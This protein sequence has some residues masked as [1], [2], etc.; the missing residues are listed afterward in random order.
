MQSPINDGDKPEI[1]LWKR[2]GL[3]QKMYE[4]VSAQA[5][6][7][8]GCGIYSFAV[9]GG[10]EVPL[11]IVFADSKLEAAQVRS[12]VI[13]GVIRAFGLRAHRTQVLRADDGYLQYV[14]LA[15][16]LSVCEKRIGIDRLLAM[17][18]HDQRISY[19][20]CASIFL[21]KP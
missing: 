7:S 6:G 21:D 16:A 4:I 17:S 5:N 3:S 10:S 19:A 1:G 12:C 18:E 15:K 9:R 2:G 20:G 14:A 8:S 13:E 11:S